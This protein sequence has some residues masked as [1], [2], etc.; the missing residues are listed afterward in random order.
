LDEQLNFVD[1]LGQA[2]EG[3]EYWTHVSSLITEPST[4][5]YIPY[6]ERKANE[7]KRLHVVSSDS[8]TQQPP[9]ALSSVE[10][11]GFFTGELMDTPTI[12]RERFD[13][14]VRQEVG[15]R[16][17]TWL[18]ENGWVVR[19]SNPLATHSMR[20]ESLPEAHILMSAN[21]QKVRYVPA[22]VSRELT[23][24]EIDKVA[25]HP[26]LLEID[27]MNVC[28]TSHPLFLQ[29]HDLASKISNLYHQYQIRTKLQPAQH[30][31]NRLVALKEAESRLRKVIDESTGTNQ[32]LISRQRQRMA[33]FQKDIRL[34]R[35][36]RDEEERVCTLHHRRSFLT[37]ID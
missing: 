18:S 36:Q 14:R 30:L 10:A 3:G 26:F 8:R 19:E 21:R 27:V 11:D 1:H 31:T 6:R 24:L 28:F 17:Q 34:V 9:D 12:P 37:L 33:E 35:R 15:G 20:S 13:S 23:S 7:R 2:I 22:Q 5:D 4:S 29:E 25:P 16:S 32:E